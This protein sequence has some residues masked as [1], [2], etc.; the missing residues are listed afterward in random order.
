MLLHFNFVDVIHPAHESGVIEQPGTEEVPSRPM[1]LD[2]HDASTL[3]GRFSV[4][5]FIPCL[6]HTGID[7]SLEMNCGMRGNSK[8]SRLLAFTACKHCF[9]GDNPTGKSF[10]WIL[11]SAISLIQNLLNLN[12]TNHLNDVVC[13]M[14]A[15]TR[16][17][18]KPKFMNN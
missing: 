7:F 8:I 17:Y 4:A 18:T 16:E 15:Y 2:C 11:I 6:N 14:I 10:D 12:H 5:R 13:P 1:F 3:S 9:L